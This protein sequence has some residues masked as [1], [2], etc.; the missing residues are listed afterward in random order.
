MRGGCINMKGSD[1]GAEPQPR[2]PVPGVPPA[3]PDRR[4]R[5]LDG[6]RALAVLAVL[7]NHAGLPFLPGGF[8][9]VDVFFVLSGTPPWRCGARISSWSGRCGMW[10]ASGGP[11]PLMS[12]SRPSRAAV[13]CRTR[14]GQIWSTSP[15]LSSCGRGPR[16]PGECPSRTETADGTPVVFAANSPERDKPHVICDL[17]RAVRSRITF[18]DV[19]AGRRRFLA[20]R[21]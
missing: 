14:N 5:A 11:W 3:A 15:C 4:L 17:G 7:A 8:I 16:R 19:R 2:R 1:G 10:K 20:H 12:H 6:V 18:C 21:R 9:G 13:T